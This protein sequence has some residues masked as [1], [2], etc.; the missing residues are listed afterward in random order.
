MSLRRKLLL[1]MTVPALLLV[2]VG[3]AGVFSVRRLERAA[4]DILADNYRTIQQARRLERVLRGIEETPPALGARR[5][6]AGKRRLAGLFEEALA[7][8]D[9]NVTEDGEHCIL[10]RIR[11]LWRA[12]GPLVLPA[13]FDRD[14]GTTDAGR[15]A[16]LLAPIFGSID[17]LVQINEEAMFAFERRERRVARL[18]LG[19]VAAASG[20]AILALVLFAIIA[21]T[22]VSRPILRIANDLEN[23]LESR[24][25]ETRSSPDSKGEIAHLRAALDD[26]LSRLGQYDEKQARRFHRLQD[27]FAFVMEESR[28]GFVLLDEDLRIVAINRVGRDLLDLPAEPEAGQKLSDLP[29]RREF[30]AAFDAA[31][32]NE[33]SDDPESGD[34]RIERDGE[35]LIIRPRILPFR[36]RGGEPAGL[37]VILWDLTQERRYEEARKRFI[38]MLSHQLK[39]PVTSLSMAVNLL[40]ERTPRSGDE[41]DELLHMAR[42]DC[43]SLARLISELVDAA[44]DVT[45]GLSVNPRRTEVARLLRQALRPLFVQ[46]REKGIEVHDR[47]GA[48]GQFA[49]VDTVKFPWVV[50]N[51]FANALRYVEEFGSITLG[52]RI[53]GDQVEVS[54]ADDGIGIPPSG[55]ERL[56]EPFTSL[57]DEPE[58]TAMGLGLSI[59]REIIQAHHGSIHV[60]SEVGVGTVF[61]I[62]V[63]QMEE[64]AR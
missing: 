57:D 29:V 22:R 52:L 41:T 15:R 58:A 33:Q 50:T 8:C 63:P 44:R 23:A 28:E 18:V 2:V 11:E 46:A 39:T 17:D 64:A 49:Q 51:V 24:D 7:A 4:E 9:E 12:A 40:W 47:M 14:S 61:R 21:A 6:E 16:R 34:V 27:R 20:G 30:A 59:A 3:L 55:I 60:E 45:P 32:G 56:F 26:L 43:Q 10:D 5:L 1:Y 36:S 31:I 38:A 25:P 54:V 42:A 19:V 62:R 35:A 13:E 48:G 53:D 37:L